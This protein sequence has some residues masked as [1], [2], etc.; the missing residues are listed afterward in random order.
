VNSYDSADV[1]MQSEE[2][3]GFLISLKSR[4]TSLWKWITSKGAMLKEGFLHWHWQWPMTMTSHTGSW[5]KLG[6]FGPFLELLCIRPAR[7]KVLQKRLT[8]TRWLQIYK[9]LMKKSFQVEYPS[10]WRTQPTASKHW[11]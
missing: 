9:E 1:R 11:M 6:S 4:I 8:H 3:L 7:Q 5:C 10:C 2:P